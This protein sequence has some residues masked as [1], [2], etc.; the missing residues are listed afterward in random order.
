MVL[1]VDLFLDGVP[2]E[3]LNEK[4]QE[5]GIERNALERDL[6]QVRRMIPRPVRRILGELPMVVETGASMVRGAMAAAR[7]T[8][9]DRRLREWL[10][11]TTPD[12]D[13]EVLLA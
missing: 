9:L 12:Q 3:V 2:D 6:A 5:L 13:P 11:D 10:E 1:A 8:G 7:R 4:L